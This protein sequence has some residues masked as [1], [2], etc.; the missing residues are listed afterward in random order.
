MNTIRQSEFAELHQLIPTEIAEL[1]RTHL[2]EGVDFWS[3][4]RVIL[5]TPEAA[6]RIR[7]IIRKEEPAAAPLTLEVR[8]IQ[9]AKNPRFVYCDLDGNRIAV[10]V[11]QKIAAK[12]KGK[13]IKVIASDG[14]DETIYTYQP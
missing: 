13:F 6:D 14:A 10:A 8:V 9:V 3:E 4:G 1:R 7:Q 2:Q 11:P 5:W 12:L